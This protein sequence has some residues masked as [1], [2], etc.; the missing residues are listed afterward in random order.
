M[1]FVEGTKIK[2]KAKRRYA[3]KFPQTDRLQTAK[4]G[5]VIDESHY[6]L[7]PDMIPPARQMFYQVGQI[8]TSELKYKK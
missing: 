2:V 6:M 4:V 7:T 3:N 8:N 1:C 5:L